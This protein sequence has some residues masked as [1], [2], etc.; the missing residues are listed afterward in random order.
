MTTLK[1]LI[2]IICMSD[3]LVC[4]DSGPMHIAIRYNVPCVALFGPVSP[5]LRVPNGANVT[6]LY[7]PDEKAGMPRRVKSSDPYSGNLN[8]IPPATVI[9]ATKEILWQK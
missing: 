6:C 1:E 7:I 3:V 4:T 9:N 5:A 8:H 2:S